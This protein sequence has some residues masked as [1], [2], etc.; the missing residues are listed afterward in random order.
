MN[1]RQPDRL[2]IATLGVRA[3]ADRQQHHV[4]GHFLRR[5][6]LHGLH[7]ERHAGIGQR[8]AGDLGAEPELQALLGQDALECFGDLARPWPATMRSRNSTTV[9]SAP[10]RRQTEPS[11]SPITPPPITTRWLGHLVELQPAGGGDDPRLVHLDAG[12]RHAF[13]AGGDDDVLRRRTP[14]R[15][16]RPCP[17]PRCGR[18]PLSQVD[19]VLA[20]Q[21]LDALDV[22]RRPPRPCAPACARGRASPRSTL[23]PWSASAWRRL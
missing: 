15:P 21:E 3:A 8:R 18:S 11:S 6:A 23:M 5:A 4:R 14:C 1:I 7:G 20:E 12:Q 2:S 9:T 13:A 19:L 22:G 10:S 16:P 17:A